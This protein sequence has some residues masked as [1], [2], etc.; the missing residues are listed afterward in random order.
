MCTLRA[1]QS[2]LSYLNSEVSSWGCFSVVLLIPSKWSVFCLA[3][4][5]PVSGAVL[6]ISARFVRLY[7]F[8][9]CILWSKSRQTYRRL[10]WQAVSDRT[11][12]AGSSA[13]CSRV[14]FTARSLNATTSFPRRFGQKTSADYSPGV[15][16]NDLCKKTLYV[17]RTRKR[18]VALDRYCY[19]SAIRFLVGF[20]GGIWRSI[21][22]RLYKRN[23][24]KNNTRFIVYI[25]STVSIITY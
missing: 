22:A 6:P 8:A 10:V 9:F 3:P 14:H 5:S 16:M 1:A 13:R 15:S 25:G 20:L 19:I 23:I 4:C 2:P 24:K 17:K 12:S 7:Y 18:E 21:N 11:H